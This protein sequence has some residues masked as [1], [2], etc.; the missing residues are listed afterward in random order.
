MKRFA[1]LAGLALAAGSA[2][3]NG[4]APLTNGIFFKPGDVQSLYVGTTFGLLISHDGGC[5]MQ[6]VCEANIGF[7][8]T[9]DPIYAIATD[10]S[11]FA[12]TVSGLRISRDGGCSFQTASTLPASTWISALDIGPTGEVWVGTATTGAPNDVYASTDNGMTFQSRGMLS[13]VIWWKS[14]KVAPS[15]AMRVYVG[16]YQVAGMPSDAG[17]QQQPAAHIMRSDD[18][19]TSWTESDITSFVFG[20]TP[21]VLVMAVDPQNPDI[22]Y[23]ISQGGNQ[24]RGDILYRSA[25][26]GGT[27]TQVLVADE[28]I[29]N[30][31][32]TP[33]TVFVATLIQSGTAYMGGP[34]YSSADHGVTFAPLANAPQLA[35]LGLRADGALIGCGANW[36]PDYMSVAK[37]TDNAMT[38]QKVW[39]F[40]DLA[41]P[42][43]CP[44]GTTEQ[45]T[46]NLQQWS[47]LQQQF[48][49]CGPSC[50]SSAVTCSVADAGPPPPKKKSGCC[51]ASGGAPLGLAW[52]GALAAWLGRRRRPNT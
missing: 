35:C 20:S 23:A 4:R 2:H 34:A 19:G 47:T 6:W 17:V 14:V 28:S 45:D 37:S 51:D 10:G 24:N 3:G 41:G 52:A 36:Q 5:T 9:P 40:V 33:T 49:S 25:D 39:R 21:I 26:A 46:C 11:I 30:V 8:G 12:T 44:S 42:L 13:P 1:V 38:W 7:S 50:G 22:V 31:V 43:S 32:I 29:Q 48:G 16:G 18:D 15:N 27:W